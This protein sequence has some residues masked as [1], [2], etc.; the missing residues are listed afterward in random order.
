[1]P[2]DR[3]RNDAEREFDTPMKL[4][5]LGTCSLFTIYGTKKFSHFHVLWNF[6][7]KAF[8]ACDQLIPFDRFVKAKVVLDVSVACTRTMQSTGA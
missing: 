7:A 8:I 4:G 6:E 3:K 1:M 2:L 5:A